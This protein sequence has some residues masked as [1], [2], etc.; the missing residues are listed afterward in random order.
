MKTRTQ[1]KKPKPKYSGDWPWISMA[2]VRTVL[3]INYP[4]QWAVV[5]ANKIKVV[6]NPRYTYLENKGYVHTEFKKFLDALGYVPIQVEGYTY[7]AR[8]H[9]KI[10]GRV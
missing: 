6:A 2:E 8:K 5:K 9:R 7:F 4:K 1:K 10:R 3:G